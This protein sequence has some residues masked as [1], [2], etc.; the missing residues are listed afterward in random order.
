M[1][2]YIDTAKTLQ[3]FSDNE[4]TVVGWCAVRGFQRPRFY[5]VVN[6]KVKWTRTAIKSKKIVEAL[7]RDGLLVTS[8]TTNQN[9][10]C[11]SC[12]KLESQGDI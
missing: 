6:N 9:I 4:I 2:T 8:I 1:T 3:K 12:S 5:E 7:K 10:S 11:S